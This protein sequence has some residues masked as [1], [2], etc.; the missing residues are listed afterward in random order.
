[1][2]VADCPMAGYSAVAQ[3]E[4]ERITERT[5][6]VR[7]AK[8]PGRFWA[9]IGIPASKINLRLLQISSRLNRST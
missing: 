8:S 4:R 3:K 9:K 5:R 2:P 1:M 7:A 6:A